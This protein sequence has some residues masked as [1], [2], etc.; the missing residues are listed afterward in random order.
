MVKVCY[1]YH[2]VCIIYI[3][4][5]IY[6]LVYRKG[7]SQ[8]KRLQIE[9]G[10]SI[11]AMIASAHDLAASQSC[12]EMDST[13]SLTECMWKTR[14]VHLQEYKTNK[15]GQFQT[16]FPSLRRNILSIYL[17]EPKHDIHTFTCLAPGCHPSSALHFLKSTS[18]SR[19]R[20]EASDD[21]TCRCRI[22]SWGW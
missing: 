22:A 17:S 5:N 3:Y 18:S 10:N 4:M 11:F 13:V 19:R 9:M 15:T 21:I 6:G 7:M 20:L 12:I 16:H 14:K 8:G 1:I 2:T